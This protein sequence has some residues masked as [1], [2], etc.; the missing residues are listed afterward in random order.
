MSWLL[1]VG[2]I[3]K[4][5]VEGNRRDYS[6]ICTLSFALNINENERPDQ[7]SPIKNSKDLS[8]NQP[9]FELFLI[10]FANSQIW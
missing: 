8:A 3:K 1:L 9:T 7:S 2:I 4:K 5:K 10:E 6:Y